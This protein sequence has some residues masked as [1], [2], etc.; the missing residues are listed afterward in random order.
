MSAE[1]IYSKDIRRAMKKLDEEMRKKRLRRA[2]H[3]ALA[4]TMERLRDAWVRHPRGRGGSLGDAIADAQVKRIKVTETGISVKVGTNYKRGGKAK[5]WHIAERGFTHYG[6]AGGQTY[7][8]FST[9]KTRAYEAARREFMV[10]AWKQMRA[11]GLP[12]GLAKQAYGKIGR[13]FDERHAPEARA[14][15]SFWNQRNAARSAARALPEASRKFIRG[16]WIS[17]P[18]ARSEFNA[19]SERFVLALR[20]QL[21]RA[22]LL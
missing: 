9:K 1:V 6:K 10:S 18:I 2:A 4:P 12:R 16:E 3:R 7:R 17:H 5:L 15:G 14:A 13:E 8:R 21:K 19:I 22:K 20:R 11:A